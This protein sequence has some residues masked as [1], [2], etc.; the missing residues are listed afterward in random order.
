MT[1]TRPEPQP[2]I[3]SH[4]IH[5]DR[6]LAHAEEMLREGDRLQASEKIW[7]AVSHA[8]KVI[9][10]ERKWPFRTHTDANV[11]AGYIGWQLA[12]PAIPEKFKAAQI[13]H[14][15]FYE[16]TFELEDIAE[17]LAS[18]EELV[19]LLRSAQRELPKTLAP[20]PSET[21][22]KRHKLRTNA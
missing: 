20:P 11:I 17:S 12:N 7:G 5:R 9:A 1:T 3:E 16:D 14:Q 19:A 21:Y 4:A 8:L 2:E 18:A 22:R 6:L 15:N 13:M 10:K